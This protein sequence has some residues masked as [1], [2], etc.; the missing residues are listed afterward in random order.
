MFSYQSAW[1]FLPCRVILIVP[2]FTHQTSGDVGTEKKKIDDFLIEDPW[3]ETLRELSNASSANAVSCSPFP[4]FLVFLLLSIAVL[5]VFLFLSSYHLPL[6]ILP[7]HPPCSYSSSSPTPPPS[8]ILSFLSS[9]VISPSSIIGALQRGLCFLRGFLRA[10]QH[11]GLLLRSQQVH[12]QTHARSLSRYWNEHLPFVLLK[13]EILT[14]AVRIAI[15]RYS[16]SRT[17]QNQSRMMG[18]DLF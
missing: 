13:P 12:S 15:A 9:S 6:K 11:N 10:R 18:I 5:L 17:L 1:P 3:M 16:I 4:V 14:N 8:F 7:Q 2:L